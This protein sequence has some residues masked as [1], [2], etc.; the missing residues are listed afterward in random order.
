MP[1]PRFTLPAAVFLLLVKDNHT[2]LLRR[3]NTGWRDG[4]FDLVA[5]HIDGNESLIQALIREAKEEVGIT[6]RADDAKFVHLTHTSFDD[7]REYFNI[8]FEVTKWVGEP[9]I[10]EPNR[11]D[12]LQWFPLDGLP[13]NLA[14]SSALGL[15]GYRNRRFYT[16]SGFAPK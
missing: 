9:A 6:V 1:Q 12:R 10:M 14:P 7:G 8:F 15:A 3:Q 4:H 16:E 11:A 2:L 5:G 13:Q